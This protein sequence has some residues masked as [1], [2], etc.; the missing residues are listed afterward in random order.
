MLHVILE[1]TGMKIIYKKKTEQQ[2]RTLGKTIVAS[3]NLIPLIRFVC[4]KD[5]N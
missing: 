2:E 4:S 3:E 5:V 1:K